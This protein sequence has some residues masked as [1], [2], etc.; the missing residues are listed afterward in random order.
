MRFSRWSIATLTALTITTM[1]LLSILMLYLGVLLYTGYQE[2]NLLEDLPTGGA[3]AYLEISAGVVPSNEHMTALVEGV[4]KLGGSTDTNLYMF[5]LVFGL[6][7]ALFCSFVGIVLTRQITRPIAE[8]IAATEGLT[9]GNFSLRVP[10][11]T[12]SR[13]VVSLVQNFNELATSLER[14]EGRL[15]FNNMAVAHEL[16]TPLTILRGSI[17]GI[18]DG[19]FEGDSAMLASLLEQVEGLSRLVEDLRTLSLAV[20]QKLLADR[21]IRDV[22]LEAKSVFE[23]ARPLIEA[24]E[25]TIEWQYTPAF[26]LIDQ[27]RI[28]QAILALLENACVYAGPGKLIR[29]ET[30]LASNREISIRII[31]HGPGFA[32]VAQ[33]SAKIDLFWRGEPSRSRSSGGTGL[34]LSIVKAIAVAHGGRLDIGRSPAGGAVVSLTL[35]AATAVSDNQVDHCGS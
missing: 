14:M 29:W 33:P 18:Q 3:Q 28:R 4:Q 25:M 27:Q 19:V 12:S 2:R 1:L 30:G 21:E 5:I 35:P 26:A 11:Q 10:A 31:D 17:Q 32:D 7:C 20:G 6:G 24:H 22:G 23:A 8:L 13:E 34:G 9:G 16:R 15:Q